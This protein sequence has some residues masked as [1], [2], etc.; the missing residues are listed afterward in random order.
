[1]RWLDVSSW[2]PGERRY[3]PKRLSLE[4]KM[5]RIFLHREHEFGVWWMKLPWRET[6]VPMQA[7]DVPGVKMEAV[8]FA[9]D[10]L[11]KMLADVHQMKSA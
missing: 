11:E 3:G 6:Y 7:S 4:G 5:F 9:Q 2:Q 8:V 10:D 1:M